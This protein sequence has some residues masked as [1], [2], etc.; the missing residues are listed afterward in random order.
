MNKVVYI[1][2]YPDFKVDLEKL[3]NEFN[4]VELTA[5]RHHSS[6][7][8]VQRKFHILKSNGEYTDNLDRFQYTLEIGKKL[9]ETLDYNSICYRSIEPNTC[10]NWHVDSGKICYHIPLITNPGSWFVYENRSF[11]MP[12]DGSIYVVNNSRPHTFANAGKTPRVHL[13]F[14]ILE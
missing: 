6:H 1:D 9:A 4:K 3:L 8:L 10:Y 12:A 13:T 2:K 5:S 7:V 14:E 11:Y